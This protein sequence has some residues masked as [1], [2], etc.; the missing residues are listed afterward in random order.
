V[1]EYA[2]A[3][4]EI[5]AVATERLRVFFPHQIAQRTTQWE[6]G[7]DPLTHFGFTDDSDENGTPDAFGRP[8]RQTTVAM[9][10]RWAKRHAVTGVP[11]VPAPDETRVLTT[12]TRTD[13]AEP[14][15]GTFIHDRVAQVKVYE[16]AVP[17]G[18]AE[19]SP[20][21]VLT[22]LRDQA[23][24]AGEVRERF[25]N[26]TGVRLV[27]HTLHHY[28]ELPVGKVGL[29]GALT[30]EETLVF[31][32]D[33]LDTAYGAWHPSYLGGPAQ[34]PPGAPA[35]AA[36]NIGYRRETS[37]PY[38]HGY[39]ADAERR[40]YSPRGLVRQLQDPLGN[41][42]SVSYDDFDL[43]PSRVTDALGM[44]TRADHNYRVLQPAKVTDPNGNVTEFAFAP[45]GLL[46][47][48][49]V[50]GKP[51]IDKGD[52]NAPSTRLAYDFFAFKDRHEPISVRTVRRERHDSEAVSDA[53][54]ETREYSDGFGRLLQTRTQAE[55]V[56]FGDARFGNGVMP[57]DQAD[58]AG[59]RLPVVGWRNDDPGNPNVVVSG[60]QIYDNK[61]R[62][63]EK[64]EPFFDRGWAYDPS[65]DAERGQKLTLF[66]DPQG[67][68][69]R[70]IN[71]DGSEQRV[72]F[73][74]PPDLSAPNDFVP[75]PWERYTYDP[76]D[77][78]PQA[79]AEHRFTPSSILSDAL[80]RDIVSVARNGHDPT[81][82]WYI[83]RYT[84]DVRGNVL[85]IIDSLGRSAFQHAY[86]LANRRLRL[87][88]I[89]AGVRLT[90]YDARGLEIERRD[91]RGAVT[92][93]TYDALARPRERWARND[94]SAT[95]TL[96]ERSVY[97]DELADQNDARER[98]LR[99]RLHHH[100]DEAGRLVVEH[101]DFK[102]NLA[103]K[104]RQV[105]RD[106]TILAPAVFSVDW[107]A[108][109]ALV[110]REYRTT[111]TYDALNRM[112]QLLYPEDSGGQR[113]VLQPTYNG[114][115]ALERVAL[116]G[117]V[118]V[119]RIAYNAR[120]QRVL[121]VY[122]NHVMTRYAHDPQ[123]FR[124]VRL[125]SERCI[126]QPDAAITYRPDGGVQQDLT[127]AYDPAGN[128]PMARDRAPGCGVGGTDALDRIFTY[129]ALYRLGSATGRESNVPAPRPPWDE[130]PH[131]YDVVA[132]RAYSQRY[133]YD[134]AGNIERIQH[135]ANG[136]NINRVFT[137]AAGSDRLHMVTVGLDDYAYTYD[138]NGNL[139]QET[140]SRFF[141]W[142]ESDRMVGFSES[143]GGGPPSQEARY[144]YDAAGQRVKKVVRK[145]GLVETTVYIDGLFEH[146]AAGGQ[147]NSR[148]GT[149]HPQ[150]YSTT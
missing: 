115:G 67:R 141:S 12:Q 76:N 2:C 1:T 124:L 54:I 53:T 147:E 29:H 110:A 96:R 58:D 108:G 105:I 139:E 59:T 33:D 81:K 48:V 142:D 118:Y 129:D 39:Y 18:V 71:P 82:E 84:Y 102:G 101:Y 3:V 7:D 55:E 133:R 109:A 150:W 49:W 106:A 94:A 135:S 92:L 4:R 86:D 37:A 65:E 61:G 41:V 95:L 128:I 62:V 146:R 89:D 104:V 22:V 10:R 100:D 123:S 90:V 36:A 116:N 93:R 9:P 117:D 91:G 83:S 68:N 97:G 35:I 75:T 38:G 60:W 131:T 111:A 138:A 145:G 112:I 14:D 140:T 80:D 27:G 136:T 143:A 16:L 121:V 20:N 98:N 8:R 30:R 56:L 103:E 6:R 122:G 52:R 11:V 73:G 23:R 17:P 149:T 19:T 69:V 57:A 46:H 13:Y 134:P 43:L 87:T 32:D 15:P 34:L 24:A 66:Y 28:D 44:E 72:V 88:S 126:S 50:R 137:V 63:V 125:R 45:L 64:Y 25:D 40:Q 42:T 85:A 113:A 99:G 78:A 74:I 5:D 70:R 77:L 144:L 127:Y 51:G 114:A 148:S 21:D 31:T 79:P 26:L 47:A 120:G 119:E 130:R 107:N 132:T